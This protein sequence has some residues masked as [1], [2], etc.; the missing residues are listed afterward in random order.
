APSAW[1]ADGTAP[2]AADA[3][4]TATAA[5]ATTATFAVAVAA[6]VVVVRPVETPVAPAPAPPAPPTAAAVE[7]AAWAEKPGTRPA[8]EWAT[9]VPGT[10]AS[11]P[12]TFAA[13]MRRSCAC[14]QGRQ[15]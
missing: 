14:R 4:T 10:R 2:T 11:A 8:I 6:V 13:R 7:V 12:A 1:W 9:C 15:V 5:L 3:A